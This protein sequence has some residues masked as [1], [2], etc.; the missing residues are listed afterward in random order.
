[1]GAE[2]NVMVVVVVWVQTMFTILFGINK[3][4]RQ[5]IYTSRENTAAEY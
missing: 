4:N 5:I 2:K 1:M 3:E